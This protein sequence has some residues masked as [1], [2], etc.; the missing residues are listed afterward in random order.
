MAT[1][2][3]RESAEGSVSYQVRVRVRGEKPRSRTFK[4]KTDAKAWAAKTESDLGHGV[5]VPTTVDRR[6]TLA[7][8]IDKT[9][10]EWL[11]IKPN[12]KDAGKV[13]IYLEWWKDHAGHVTLDKLTPQ[14]IGEYRSELSKRTNRHGKSISGATVNRYLAALSVA[15]KWAWKELGW[16]PSNPVL[17]VSKRAENPP[18]GKRLT[19]DERHHL[20]TA[21]RGSSDPNI[22]TLVMLALATGCRYSNLR[23]LQWDDVDMDAWTFSLADT[24]NGTARVVPIIGAAQAAVRDQFEV[25]FT[26]GGWVFKGQ[27]DAKPAD[28]TP[29]WQAVR[30]AAGLDGFRFHDLR[31]TVGTVLTEAGA[32]LAEVAAALGQRT[33]VMA[34]RYVHQSE[35]HVRSVLEKGLA[36]K[37]SD[38]E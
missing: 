1:I 25:D 5:Y 26:G 33:L 15:T 21:C 7:D 14:T 16:L 27:T 29:V 32:S 30:D 3:R 34:H 36:G 6:R 22:Y 37:L 4:R 9:V 2:V 17:S 18:P 19:D 8:L 11:P 23:F 28:M 13:A 12:N 38:K 24:K 31:H 10:A 20:L 35:G